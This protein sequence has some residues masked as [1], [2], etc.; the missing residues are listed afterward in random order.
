MFGAFIL[1][2]ATQQEIPLQRI[3]YVLSGNYFWYHVES[4]HL[5]KYFSCIWKIPECLIPSSQ[6]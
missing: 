1:G 6:F 3:Q 2:I 4:F 5:K